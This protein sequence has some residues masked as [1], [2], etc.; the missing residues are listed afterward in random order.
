M[1]RQRSFALALLGFDWLRFA[2]GPLT[3]DLHDIQLSRKLGTPIPIHSP[4]RAAPYLRT[5]CAPV[6]PPAQW[7]D[8]KIALAEA[9]VHKKIFIS[10]ILLSKPMRA[11]NIAG[12]HVAADD[13]ISVQTLINAVCSSLAAY[14]KKGGSSVGWCCYRPPWRSRTICCTCSAWPDAGR[15][16]NRARQVGRFAIRALFPLSLLPFRL[17][18]L[19]AVSPI[20]PWA[21][22]Y[23]GKC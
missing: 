8:S 10:W 20:C 15:R 3:V 7:P 11:G 1:N 5:Y 6:T 19:P 16:R 17:P 12:S 18:S 13:S 23:R 21:E 4:N 14:L 22:E 2:A 9:N